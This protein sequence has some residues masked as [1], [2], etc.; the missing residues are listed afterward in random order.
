MPGA[1][2]AGGTTFGLL[3]LRDRLRALELVSGVE[4][5]IDETDLEGRLRSADLV[6]TGEGRIDAQTAFG[7]T[8]LGV[9]RRAAAAGLACIAVGG[10]VEP[11]GITA[12][13]EFGAIVIPVAER[14]GSVEEAMATGAAPVERAAER[15]ARLLTI[16]LSRSASASP[17]P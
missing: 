1:G 8:A 3:C 13:A 9:A 5:V 4:L 2:A 16:G 15:I 12:L 11:E 10:G 17:S 6:V 14:P 7:K